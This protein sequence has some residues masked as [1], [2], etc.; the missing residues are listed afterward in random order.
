M[1]G[2]EGIETVRLY[3][4]TTKAVFHLYPMRFISEG[5]SGMPRELFV[6]A[7]K[8][9]GVPCSTGYSPL[10]TQP[11]I[12]SAFESKLYQK[13]YDRDEIDYDA[14]LEANKCPESDSLCKEE[15]IWIAQSMLLTDSAA[16]DDIAAAVGK[17]REN[18]DKIIRKYKSGEIK[19]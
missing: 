9:E 10:Q 19:I 16:M 13:V 6:A 17:I 8:A 15:A 5:F 3:P 2:I 12:K 1:K 4:K 18:A 14:F 7:M 11:F